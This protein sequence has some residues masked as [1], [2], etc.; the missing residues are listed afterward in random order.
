[1]RIVGPP[2]ADS[3]TVAARLATPALWRHTRFLDEMFRPLW[4]AAAA[5][6]IDPV[7]IIAQAYK[8]TAGGAFGGR[9]TPQHYNPCGLKVRHPGYGGTSTTGD[10]QLA[11]AAFASWDVG[12]L[13]HV[14]HVRKY[15]GWPVNGL[16]VDP[17]YWLVAGQ[18]CEDWVDLSG[19]WAPSPTYGPEIETLMA[20]LRVAV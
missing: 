16:I 6:T 3:A 1:M 19:K 12:A 4:D 9:V 10:E 8:E 11:H 20:R 5:H 14:Q 2:S 18:P 17:R 7:G 13:A 15:T